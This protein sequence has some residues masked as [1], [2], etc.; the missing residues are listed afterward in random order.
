MVLGDI[1]ETFDA[2]IL[3]ILDFLILW[4]K[5]SCNGDISIVAVALLFCDCGGGGGDG[6]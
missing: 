4:R 2:L 3:D 5:L 6:I 1:F